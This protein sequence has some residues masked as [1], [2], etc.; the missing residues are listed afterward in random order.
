MEKRWNSATFHARM[1]TDGP[2]LVLSNFLPSSPVAPQSDKAG[3]CE[4]TV[5]NRTE[6]APAL[7]VP[8]ASLRRS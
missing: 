3:L 1:V 2:F 7:I 4:R 6:A 8:T 5:R